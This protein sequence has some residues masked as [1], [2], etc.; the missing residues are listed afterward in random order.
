MEEGRVCGGAGSI[1]KREGTREGGSSAR[2][3]RMEAERS[4][5]GSMMD[6]RTSS[7]KAGR[8][9]KA[10]LSERI[11]QKVTAMEYTSLLCPLYS[12]WNCSGAMY[13]ADPLRWAPKRRASASDW[14][15]WA[16]PK[17]ASRMV[18][19]SIEERMFS[20][21]MSLCTHCCL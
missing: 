1:L 14:I 11:S 16:N 12:A 6:W 2:G 15:L 20:G 13:S 17:S 19:D 9:E 5:E 3:G 18:P 21:L 7:S 8:S 10:S 4:L